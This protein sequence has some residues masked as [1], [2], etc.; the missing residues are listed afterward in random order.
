MQI[1]WNNFLLFLGHTTQEPCNDVDSCAE[2]VDELQK[3]V[4]E[5]KRALTNQLIELNGRRSN[6]STRQ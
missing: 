2:D 5:Q 4:I 1:G 3:E 6:G